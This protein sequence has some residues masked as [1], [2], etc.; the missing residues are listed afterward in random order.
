MEIEL[1]DDI[2][3]IIFRRFVAVEPVDWPLPSYNK[4]CARAPFTLAAVCSSWRFL[5]THT[6]TLWTYFGFPSRTDEHGKHLYRLDTLMKLSKNAPIDVVFNWRAPTKFTQDDDS[7]SLRILKTLHSISS[8]WRSAEIDYSPHNL[9]LSSHKLHES[10]APYLE[11]LIIAFRSYPPRLPKA[12]RLRQLYLDSDRLDV[13]LLAQSYQPS[14]THLVVW[15]A[16]F[17]A[18]EAFCLRHASQLTELC[19]L[20]DLDGYPDRGRYEFPCLVSLTLDDPW[21]MSRIA[22]PQLKCLAINCTELRE[23]N[24]EISEQFADIVPQLQQLVVWGAVNSLVILAA[25]EHVQTLQ[26]QRP[27]AVTKAFDAGN[28]YSLIPE[29]LHDLNKPTPIVWPRLEQVIF[30]AYDSPWGGQPTMTDLDTDL[31]TFVQTRY[32]CGGCNVKI[33]GRPS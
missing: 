6:C 7:P 1:P 25:F 9:Q 31:A 4:N 23:E 16:D 2:L 21:F 5:I 18:S 8:R 27:A 28:H 30:G 13:S 20:E 24:R 14:L 17:A 12:P 32:S 11:T 26:F 3:L 22:A 29:G 33:H 15:S 10:E 19:I